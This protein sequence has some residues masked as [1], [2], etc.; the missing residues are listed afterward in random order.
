[1]RDM[2][3]PVEDKK[4]VIGERLIKLFYDGVYYAGNKDGVYPFDEYMSIYEMFHDSGMEDE[5]VTA[6]KSLPD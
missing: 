1:M 3:H 5:I 4:P 2:L 6:A